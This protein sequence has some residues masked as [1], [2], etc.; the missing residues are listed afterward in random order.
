MNF[1]RAFLI[2]VIVSL[3]FKPDFT[4]AQ[5]TE[6]QR[7]AKWDSLIFGGRF[8]DRFLPLPELGGLTYDTWGSDGVLPRD[9]NNGIE[10]RK[11]SY[12]GGNIRQGKDGKYHMFVCR[13]PENSRKGHMTWPKSEVVHAVSVNRFGPYKPVKVVGKGHNPEWYV[14]KNG[15]YVISVIGKYYISDSINGPWEKKKFDMDNRGKS[16]IDGLSNLTFAQRED[17]SYIMISRGGGVWLSDDGVSTW[18]RV[19]EGSVYPDVN[20]EFEDPVIW[21]TNV[22]YHLIVND[23]LG[24]IAWHLRSKD[25]IHWKTD[26]GEAYMPGIARRQ[27]GS[28]E[29]WFKF[30]R[31]KVLQDE[32]GRAV[33]ANFAVIDTLKKQDLPNDRHSSKNLVIPLVKGKLIT[34]LN[35]EPI[36]ENTIRIRI[37]VKSEP[38]F[39][40]IKDI[41]FETL[42]FGA[43]ETVDYGKGCEIIS[44]EPDELGVIITFEGKNNGFSKDNFAGK[45]L[46][47]DK[48]GGLLFGYSRLPGVDYTVEPVEKL[49][50]HKK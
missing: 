21:R 11:W 32:Y 24:R 4:S 47:K 40:A 25:G 35:K 3:I 50:K 19:S 31:M 48:N 18:H 2:L 12:W 26:P 39:D 15:K 8:M 45:L 20:G 34:V 37:L 27:D 44:Y 29:K 28:V 36:D 38:G 42:K 17:G 43:P 13:W 9:T 33:Q 14:S 30:E 49:I 22:Q 10:S 16:I 23:W 1:K 6:R 5:V 46:G 41:D 7:P